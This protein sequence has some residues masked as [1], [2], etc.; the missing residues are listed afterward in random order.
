MTLNVSN[1]FAISQIVFLCIQIDLHNLTTWSQHWSLNFN[2]VKC[3]LLRFSSGCPPTAFNYIIN[4]DLISAQE[5]HRDLGIIMSSDL[6][7]R[8][9]MKNILSRAYKTLNLIQRLFSTG[10]SPQTKK[11]LYLSL[12]RSQLK[13]CSQIWRPHLLKD[14]IILE[15][16]QHCATR[17]IL[18]DFIRSLKGPTDAFNI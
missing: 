15:K 13:Y 7:W 4:G 2:A 12:V 18:N 14:I 3:A 5:T 9:H 1:L 6:S 17:Y 8:E 10:H 16:I 11:I